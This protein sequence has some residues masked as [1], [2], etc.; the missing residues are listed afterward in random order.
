MELASARIRSGN[1]SLGWVGSWTGL[2]GAGKAQEL[3]VLGGRMGFPR[4]LLDSDFNQAQTVLK[5]GKKNKTGEKKETEVLLWAGMGSHG[6]HLCAAL[7][8]RHV[9][10]LLT[11]PMLPL[12][13]KKSPI[14]SFFVQRQRLRGYFCCQKVGSW[15]FPVQLG[16]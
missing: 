4:S 11:A 9:G 15:V 7:Q 10:L 14:H 8:E 13:T 12:C 1:E 3:C 6:A 5:Q 2:Q 16:K